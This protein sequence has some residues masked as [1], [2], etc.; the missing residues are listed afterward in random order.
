MILAYIVDHDLG[1][2]PNPFYGACTLATCKPQIREAAGPG[3]WIVGIGSKALKCRGRLIFAMCVS[4]K[5]TFD[6]YW[7][8]RRYQEKK[9]LFTGSLKQAQ[10][11]NIYHR[12]GNGPWIQEKSRHSHPDPVM[13]KRHL[14]RDTKSEYVLVGEQFVYYGGEA[15][16]IPSHLKSA[17]Q[18]H[19][20]LSSEGTPGGHF[21]RQR[22]FEDSA[23]EKK[24]VVWL[25]D[26]GKWGYQGD[27]HEWSSD[28][29]VYR[30]LQ[31]ST[32]TYPGE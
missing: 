1:F 11:D 6:Q 2:A 31:D 23:L 15:I 27:P 16:E 8:D 10:G 20:S 19:L 5:L 24:L 22:Y 9:P 28:P 14:E 7:I 25:D 30:F 4:E 13:E 12:A 3:D 17:D 21:A 18:R 32:F 26:V 29:N